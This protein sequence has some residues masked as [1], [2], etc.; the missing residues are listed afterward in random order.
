MERPA[1][2]RITKHFAVGCRL[3]GDCPDSKCMQAEISA[4]FN[5][6]LKEDFT[7]QSSWFHIQHGSLVQYIQISKCNAPF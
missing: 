7:S 5:M 6:S 4:L 1:I 2:G 3:L